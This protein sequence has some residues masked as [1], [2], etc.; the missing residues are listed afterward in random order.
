MTYFFL[1]FYKDCWGFFETKVGRQTKIVLI[2]PNSVPSPELEIK[3]LIDLPKPEYS[4]LSTVKFMFSKKA[5]KIN[6]TF[7]VDLKLTT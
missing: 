4:E 3:Q 1:P 5:T 2:G 7:T 6:E